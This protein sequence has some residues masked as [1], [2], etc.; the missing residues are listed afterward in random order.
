MYIYL[1]VRT[2]LIRK[3]RIQLIESD[4]IPIVIVSRWL[5]SSNCL[6]LEFLEYENT[7]RNSSRRHRRRRFREQTNPFN[8]EDAEFVQRYR[9]SKAATQTLCQELRPFLTPT[10]STGLSVQTKVG[11]Y[12]NTHLIL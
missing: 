6:V 2:D 9:L 10:R 4:V 3:Y 5:M 1:L 11:T 12:I 8:L 7:A